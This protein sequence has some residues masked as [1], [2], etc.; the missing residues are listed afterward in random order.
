[1]H[2]PAVVTM[3]L[4]LAQFGAPGAV[5]ALEQCV[6][7]ADP[8]VRIYGAVALAMYQRPAAD[9]ALAREVAGP[10]DI[11]VRNT[12]AELLLE[13]GD[14]RGLLS[15]LDAF[16]RGAELYGMT[17]N[18]EAG[19]NV[20]LF[21]CKDLRIYTQQ[22]LPCDADAPA[23]VRTAQSAAWRRWLS[24]TGTSFQV[25]RRAAALDLE[26]FPLIS[27]IAIGRQIAR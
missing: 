7:A 23:D 13:L 5:T 15:R 21:A 18:G 26:A 2:G 8:E 9:E 22:P 11:T 27:P 20:R 10:G 4:R 6:R 1:M 16:E 14:R 19:R 24:A 3:L 12:A 17:N 25:P